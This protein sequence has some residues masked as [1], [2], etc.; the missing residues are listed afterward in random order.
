MVIK[1]G[2]FETLSLNE[3][4]RLAPLALAVHDTAQDFDIA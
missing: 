2:L 3:I 1:T 4:L